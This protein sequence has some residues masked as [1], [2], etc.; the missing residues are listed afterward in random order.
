[1]AQRWARLAGEH[2]AVQRG[3]CGD[4]RAGGGETGP[5]REEAVGLLAGKSLPQVS[6]EGSCG[7]LFWKNVPFYSVTVNC[8]R[9]SL[10]LCWSNAHVCGRTKITVCTHIYVYTCVH[11]HTHVHMYL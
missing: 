11:V 1:M 5:S 9:M 6:A 10:C 8:R 7:L 3:G 4:T 2:R